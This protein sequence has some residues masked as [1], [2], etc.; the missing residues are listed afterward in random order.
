MLSRCILLASGNGIGSPLYCSGNA[1]IEG[2]VATVIAN[3]RAAHAILLPFSDHLSADCN[4]QDLPD[5][6]QATGTIPI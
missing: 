2:P 3:L 4:R 5:S 6:Y 1:G